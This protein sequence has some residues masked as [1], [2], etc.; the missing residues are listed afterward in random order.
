[1][2]T[3]ETTGAQPGPRTRGTRW[4]AGGAV[5]S[6]ALLLAAGLTVPNA[7]AAQDAGGRVGA[8]GAAGGGGDSCGKD[9]RTGRERGDCR[10]GPRGPKGPPGPSGP[11]GPPGPPGPSGPP[12]EPGAIGPSGPA[13]P[14]GPVGPSGPPGPS[15]S[16]GPSGPPGP[17]VNVGASLFSLLDQGIPNNI[18]TKINFSG[19]AYDTDGMYDPANSAL[20]VRTGGRYL[21]TGR[22]L[23]AYNTNPTG[24]RS[25]QIRVNG[26]ARALDV[27]DTATVPGTGSASQT[28]SA[29]LQLD[30]GDVI[31]LYALQRTGTEAVSMATAFGD[32]TVA[33]QLTAELLVPDA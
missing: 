27:Q 2:G 22:I 30:A 16:P 29:I 19:A 33:P 17:T 15:A 10:K 25:L 5:A 11:P 8:Y 14:S 18:A 20:V 21:L 4:T 9:P 12:G 3:E 32:V 6:L 1:M 31:S 7:L 26:G 23:L 24:D 13:G 28:V